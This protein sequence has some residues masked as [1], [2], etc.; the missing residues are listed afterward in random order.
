MLSGKKKKT[1]D[2]K[3]FFVCI[4]LVA[5]LEFLMDLFIICKEYVDKRHVFS[6]V[7]YL[8]V[9]DVMQ[10]FLRHIQDT[11]QPLHLNISFI[12]I[13]HGF[14]YLVLLHTCYTSGTFVCEVFIYN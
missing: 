3:P 12:F 5:F 11:D 2:T 10:L 4:S 7:F 1:V 13:F 8:V 9:A 14:S 6:I